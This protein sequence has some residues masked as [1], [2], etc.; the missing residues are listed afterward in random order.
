M[1]ERRSISQELSAIEQ[2]M[3]ELEIRYE[4]YFNG[5]EKREPVAAREG[6]AKRLRRFAN[7]KITQTDLRYKYQTLAGRYHSYS[8]YW[9]RILRL[10]DEGRYHRQAPPP[11]ASKPGR[12]GTPHLKEGRLEQIYQ[13]L[14][15][16]HDQCNSKGSA[17][18]RG[19]LEAFLENQLARIQD[20]FGAQEVEFRVASENGKP[21]I[22]VRAKK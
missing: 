14:L 12:Q 19:Q 11:T 7:R 18:S 5:V 8:G 13:E 21:K 2:A 17:P 4:Q 1:K 3:K 6:V 20:K 15:Q 16:A 10:M 22:K 9:D